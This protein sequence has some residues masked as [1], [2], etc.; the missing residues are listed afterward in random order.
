MQVLLEPY[1]V[2][3]TYETPM[4]ADALTRLRDPVSADNPLVDR[5]P[6]ARSSSDWAST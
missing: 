1:P 4:A 6:A 5:V 3:V 2:R